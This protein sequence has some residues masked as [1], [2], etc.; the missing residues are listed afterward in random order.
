MDTVKTEIK[1]D[2]ITWNK[3]VSNPAIKETHSY[4]TITLKEVTDQFDWEIIVTSFAW[5]FT[6]LFICTFFYSQLKEI[7]TGLAERIKGGDGVEFGLSGIKITKMMD[8]KQ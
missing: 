7:L 6:I 3:S 4:K 2:A 1:I 5:P 8:S